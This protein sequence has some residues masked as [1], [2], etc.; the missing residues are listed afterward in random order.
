[1]LP[2]AYATVMRIGAGQPIAPRQWSVLPITKP[3]FLGC[4]F[5][6]GSGTAEG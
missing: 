2:A 1:V 4:E 6:T 3:W 5:A